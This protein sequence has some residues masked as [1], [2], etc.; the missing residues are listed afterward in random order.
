VLAA[1]A[2]PLPTLITVDAH[3]KVRQAVDLLQEH[4]ISQ[5]PVVR[6]HSTDVAQFVGS[7]RDRELLERVFRDP[8]ALQADVAEVMAPPIPTI[9]RHA[10]VDEAF[11][12]LER[13][14]AVLVS[15]GEVVI[16]VLTRSDLLDF[17]AHHRQAPAT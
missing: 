13:A 12:E 17:L 9:E 15:A 11:S 2:G 10:S 6:D 3:D 7:I 5:A 4:G 16:G 14:P 8:D 1:K